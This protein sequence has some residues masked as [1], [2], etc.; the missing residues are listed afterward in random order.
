MIKN[1]FRF[2]KIRFLHSIGFFIYLFYLWYIATLKIISINNELPPQNRALGRNVIF[3]FWHSKTF[4]LM[5]HCRDAKIG[6]LTLLDWK[7]I[8]YDK[9]CQLYGYQ[10]IPVTSLQKATVRLKKILE[11]GCAVGLALDGPRGPAGVA[12]PGAFFLAKTTGKPIITV[13]VKASK[14]FRIKSRWD[15]YEIPLPFSEVVISFSEPFKVAP[16][17]EE[18][19]ERM[20][21]SVL[22]DL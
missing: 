4:A 17:D 9:V 15:Q 8:I 13:N 14:S 3:A 21:G 19:F 10:T 20:I 2:L 6:V 7:N 16:G 11:E 22:K 5:P 1:L 18:K 12:K